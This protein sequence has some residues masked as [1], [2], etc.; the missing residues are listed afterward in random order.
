[1]ECKRD[2]Y[3][4]PVIGRHLSLLILPLIA[5]LVLS[6][7]ASADEFAWVKQVYDGDTIRLEDG[8]KVRYLGV[9]AP[10]FQESFYLK[11]KRFNESLVPG[12]QVRLEFDQERADTYGRLLAYV[13]VADQ[14]VNATLVGQGLAHAFFIGPN[15]KHNSQILRLQSEA[16]QRRLGI[17]SVRAL[18][19]DLKITSVHP[20][21][22]ANP[23]PHAPYVRITNLSDRPIRTT[24]H[25][26]SNEGGQRY[27]FPDVTV[28]PGYTVIVASGPGAD[29]MDERGQLVVH[30]PG[31]G[32]VWDTREDTAFL[33]NAA[34][35]VV[36]T[37]HYKGKRVTRSPRPSRGKG[38]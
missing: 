21:D 28:D 24:G 10:E 6:P 35:A 3:A 32:A 34:G 9:N 16:K 18:P 27:L 25:I 2:L 7:S 20:P 26:L 17:W 31:Q 15:R 33:L 29:G 36:D 13:Y 22:P 4:G 1:M 30:W 8:R 12:R 11:A 5:G 37:F 19:R 38:S 14:M 23:E